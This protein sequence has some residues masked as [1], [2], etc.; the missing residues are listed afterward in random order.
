[1][2]WSDIR[3]LYLVSGWFICL[4]RAG[5]SFIKVRHNGKWSHRRPEKREG[6]KADIS[7]RP[8]EPYIIFIKRLRVN[9]IAICKRRNGGAER[10]GKLSKIPR[11]E[12]GRSNQDLNPGLFGSKEHAYLVNY[13]E[14]HRSR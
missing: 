9:T 1:M 12:N 14:K 11:S 2:M 4:Q 6:E 8:Y 7:E 13:T 3:G 5:L 10:L